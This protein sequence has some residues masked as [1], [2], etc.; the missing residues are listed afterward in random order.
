ME[1]QIEGVVTNVHWF[2]EKYRSG[3]YLG[4]VEGNQTGTGTLTITPD[5]D[6]PTEAA[7][8]ELTI[9]GETAASSYPKGTG[10]GAKMVFTRA[11]GNTTCETK[12]PVGG[13]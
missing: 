12:G 11:S 6:W 3:S 10:P 1:W 5:S 2:L 4:I 8:V 9:I 7:T 13:L